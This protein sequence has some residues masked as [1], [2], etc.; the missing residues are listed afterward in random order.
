MEGICHSASRHATTDDLHRILS[1]SIS[2]FDAAITLLDEPSAEGVRMPGPAHIA[3]MRNILACL[4]TGKNEGEDLPVS[5][6]H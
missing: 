2:I 1:T 4:G 5:R 6:L 3:C